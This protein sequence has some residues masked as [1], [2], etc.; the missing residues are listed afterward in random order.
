MSGAAIN[1]F[2]LSTLFKQLFVGP[3]DLREWVAY[4]SDQTVGLDDLVEAVG[5]GQPMV[6]VAYAAAQAIVARMD[7]ELEEDRAILRSTL[8]WHRGR[9]RAAIEHVLG[10]HGSTLP[11]PRPVQPDPDLMDASD[12]LTKLI[13][14]RDARR[15]EGRDTA[16]VDARIRD[17][18]GRLR[19][20]PI[21]RAGEYLDDH[22]YQLIQTLGQGGFGRVWL[23]W[24]RALSSHV[25]LKVVHAQWTHEGAGSVVDRVFSGARRMAEVRHPGIVR[26]LR[27]HVEDR[28]FHF[29]VMAYMAGGDLHQAVV[30]GVVANVAA[31]RLVLDV[32]DALAHAHARGLVHR[33]MKPHNMLLGE[34]GALVLAD[35]DFVNAVGTTHGTHTGAAMGTVVYAAP[36][37]IEDAARADWRAD[38]YGLAMSVVFCLSGSDVP[39]EALY[40]P[41]A[42]LSRLGIPADLRLLLQHA[43]ER[44]PAARD[45][46]VAAFCEA[47]RALLAPFDDATSF[48]DLDLSGRIVV[49]IWAEET[50]VRVA[51]RSV[52]I[53]GKR[54]EIVRETARRTEN[55]GSVHWTVVAAVIWP[56]NATERNWQRTRARLVDFL[57]DNEL[58]SDLLDTRHGQVSLSLNRHRG[59][60]IIFHDRHL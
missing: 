17:L 30:K 18:G 41:E 7:L 55:G 48:S 27:D 40:A 10:A 11:P 47:A 32:G 8:L 46:P 53:V 43:L 39:F 44:D 49:E 58:P 4:L 45:T 51:G 3:P 2:T 16:A 6:E 9:H 52:R 28:G 14:E 57:I 36:E 38:L 21:L 5:W 35:F 56:V 19:G 24:D 42:Y 37:L 15:F 12:E 26:I 54:H 22:R 25:A 60:R 1:A 23:A 59:D 33:D 20:G 50:N 29:L 34:D 31:A 13:E